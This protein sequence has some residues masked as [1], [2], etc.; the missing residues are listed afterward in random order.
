MSTLDDFF[1]DTNQTQDEGWKYETGDD[2]VQRLVITDPT[3]YVAHRARVEAEQA[4]ENLKN[5][6]DMLAQADDN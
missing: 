5:Y 2:G 6:R 3:K 1:A 4:A